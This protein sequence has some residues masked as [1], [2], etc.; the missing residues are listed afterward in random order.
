M[1]VRENWPKASQTWHTKMLAQSVMY[2]TVKDD[3]L[4]LCKIKVL[5][6]S[7]A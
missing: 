7:I 1:E 4:F 6:V 5:I 2:F 3:L